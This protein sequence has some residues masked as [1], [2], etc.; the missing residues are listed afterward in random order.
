M[1]VQKNAAVQARS[2]AS[3]IDFQGRRYVASFESGTGRIA[4]L[5][6]RVVRSGYDVARKE[7]SNEKEWHYV[8]ASLHRLVPLDF[9]HITGQPSVRRGPEQPYKHVYVEMPVAEARKVMDAYNAQKSPDGFG[10][11]LS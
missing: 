6:G 10:S 4:E 3:I 7:G 9:D 8:P 5:F 2:Y 11:P 1:V